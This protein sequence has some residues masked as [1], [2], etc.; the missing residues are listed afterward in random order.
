MRVYAVFFALLCLF[1]ANATDWSR[2]V[3]VCDFGAKGDGITD[4]TMAIQ[5]ALNF[6]REKQ[7]IILLAR[8]PML[9]GAPHLGNLPVLSSTS[10]NVMVPELF[11]P[12]GNYKISSTLVAK[13]YLYMRGEKG[14]K[15]TQ[16]APDKDILYIEWGFRVQITNLEFHNGCRHIVLWT[17]NE[18]TAN[19]T[20][21]NCVF[22]NSSGTAF[23]SY[24]FLNPK[25]T[26]FADTTYG[27]YSVKW[28]GEKPILTLNNEN[29]KHFNNSTLFTFGDCDFINCAEIFRFNSDGAVIENCNVQI[30]AD[31]TASPFHISGPTSI[32][33][34]NATADKAIP[35]KAWF[36]NPAQRLSICGSSFTVKNGS[37]MPLFS[38]S[39]EE[40][41]EVQDYLI[42]RNTKVQCGKYPIILCKG[43]IPHIIDFENVR[44][45]S[46]KRV[47]LMGGA[48]NITRA[49][50]K[51]T[52]MNVDIYEKV[53]SGKS[54]F[55][56]EPPYDITLSGCD[57]I[58]MAG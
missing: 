4:D 44:D 19:F 24:N 50:L 47:M 7:Q 17:G 30:S 12:S 25:R 5:R 22:K 46:G 57:T 39:R 18:D 54:H 10:E 41:S 1:A 49:D 32:I 37:G 6:I 42:V 33:N 35:G 26:N 3:N 58:S 23:Y 34:L 31:A 13:S 53:L 38:Y 27:L 8:Q 28:Q 36:D 51:K 20:V 9:A 29:E 48:E 43:S 21:E 15:I 14:S 56:K 52:E 40:A 16:A 55:K 45:I 2:G 11:F